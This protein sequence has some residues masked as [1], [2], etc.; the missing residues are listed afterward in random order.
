MQRAPREEAE[1][2]TGVCVRAPGVRQRRGEEEER[3]ADGV[4]A[5][6]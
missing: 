3:G 5:Y 6:L 1:A 2:E 4:R